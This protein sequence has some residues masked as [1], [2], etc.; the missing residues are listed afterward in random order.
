MRKVVIV[1]PARGVF[2]G[3]S[4]G[5]AYFS[6]GDCG[7]QTH[8]PVFTDEAEAREFIKSWDAPGHGLTHDD[9][10]YFELASRFNCQFADTTML[11]HAGVSLAMIEPILKIEVASLRA[12]KKTGYL[13]H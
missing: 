2:L 13:P 11:R 3:H 1:H 8:A 6:N 9:F 7:K 5:Y 4:N 12:R 10:A